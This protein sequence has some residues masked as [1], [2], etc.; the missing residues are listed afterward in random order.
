MPEVYAFLDNF[1]WSPDEMAELLVWN[2]EEDADP[3]ENAKRWIKENPEKVQQW[4]P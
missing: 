2:Q 4:L 1:S 3:Y